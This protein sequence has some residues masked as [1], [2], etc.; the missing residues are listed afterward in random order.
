MRPRES[1]EEAEREE[2]TGGEREDRGSKGQRGEGEREGK[3]G[4]E[5]V[6][7]RET[8]SWTSPGLSGKP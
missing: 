4:W 1:E 2:G 7:R 3:V 6:G 8:H 5:R